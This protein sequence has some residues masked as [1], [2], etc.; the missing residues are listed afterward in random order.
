MLILTR[1]EGQR[2]IVGDNVWVHLCCINGN[3]AQI[4]I[5]APKNMQVHREEVYKRIQQ[6]K[7][8]ARGNNIWT[9][10]AR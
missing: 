6:E 9:L 2:I 3:Q 8:D 1:K 7:L 5:D 4:G 10:T